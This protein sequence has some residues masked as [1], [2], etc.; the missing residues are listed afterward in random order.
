VFAFHGT[1]VDHFDQVQKVLFRC[2]RSDPLG[3]ILS[4]KVHLHV[5]AIEDEDDCGNESNIKVVNVDANGRGVDKEN[6]GELGESLLT[7]C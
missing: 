4:A 7:F 6:R 3:V 1:A 5:L 2:K